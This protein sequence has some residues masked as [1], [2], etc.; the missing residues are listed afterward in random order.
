M[1]DKPLLIL[2]RPGAASRALA[3][4]LGHAPVLVAPLVG[5]VRRDPGPIGDVAGVVLTSANGLPEQG[6]LGL[7]GGLPAWCVG[8]RT[9]Q[10]ARQAGFEARHA[11]GDAA[12]L[13]AWLRVLRPPAPLVHLR[14][15]H[16]RGDVAGALGRAG[17]ACNE[18]V[19]YAQ[20]DLPPSAA[21]RAAW[22]GS[23]AKVA[24]VYSPLGA[25]RLA[26]L[27]PPGGAL[28]V[29]AISRAAAARLGGLAH[30]VA[31]EPTGQAME[32]ALRNAL[33]SPPPFAC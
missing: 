18:V 25:A 33:D 32:A 21:L 15:D 5:I 31:A 29:I 19:T 4:A 1:T 20:R 10:A 17:I 14:G 23:G 28:R 2:T 13:V 16:A 27:G 11:D 30:A 7:P 26:A 22:D 12:A 24:P 8:A 3:S 6:R 9:A